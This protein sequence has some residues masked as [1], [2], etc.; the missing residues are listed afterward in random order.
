DVDAVLALH[1][2]R[3]VSGATDVARAVADVARK[4]RKPILAAWLGAINR[5]EVHG[6]LAAGGIADFYTPENAIDAFAFLAAYR[7]NQAWL[8]E[9]PPPAPEPEPPNLA[10]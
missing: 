8:L 3:P 5:R 9:V 4:S 7:R 2:P 6:A 1:V 10:A